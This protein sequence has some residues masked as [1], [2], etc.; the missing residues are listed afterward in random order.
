[1]RIG[2]DV[3]ISGKI[4][5]WISAYRDIHGETQIKWDVVLPSGKRVFVQESDI[6][7]Y[8]PFHPIPEKDERRGQ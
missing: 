3:I 2:D 5:G 7:A 6:K 8:H 4:V 1:M